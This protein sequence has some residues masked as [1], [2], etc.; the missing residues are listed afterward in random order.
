MKILSYDGSNIEKF[1]I[2]G[3]FE[4]VVKV[5]DIAIMWDCIV[6]LQLL[7]WDNLLASILCVGVLL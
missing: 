1:Q 6:A 5:F 4:C 3:S 2:Y 7:L